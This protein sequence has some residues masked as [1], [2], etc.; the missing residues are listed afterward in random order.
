MCLI[1]HL[2]NINN[3]NIRKYQSHLQPKSPSVANADIIKKCT[4]QC[5]S[6]VL[7]CILSYSS[8]WTKF[9]SL[10][11]TPVLCLGCSTYTGWCWTIL[12]SPPKNHPQAYC[13]T[14]GLILTH[15]SRVNAK[16]KHPTEKRIKK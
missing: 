11:K 6:K 8:Y 12:A 7:N 10:P 3:E 16:I 5:Q 4:N 15:N 2:N 9:W 13:L 14:C 1:P